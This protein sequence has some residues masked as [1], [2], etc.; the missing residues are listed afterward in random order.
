MISGRVR[1]EDRDP[2]LVEA[3]REA[4]RLEQLR[5]PVDPCGGAAGVVLLRD[6]LDRERRACE[7]VHAD[8]GRIEP[9]REVV[10]VRDHH[11]ADAAATSSSRVP[12]VR[13][14]PSRSPWPG[15]YSD[16]VPSASRKRLPS[17][18]RRGAADWPNR[19][20]SP[21]RSLGDVAAHRL[22]GREARHQRD[23][24]LG[25]ER[26]G[27]PPRLRELDLEEAP[28]VERLG[29]RL[30]AAAEP[31]RHAAREDDHRDLARAQRLRPAATASS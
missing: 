8:D 19:S 14:Q 6:D 24:D 5:P 29:D 27:E 30:D 13:T 18:R 31:R 9:R 25:A 4:E 10:D 20:G 3:G 12:E 7:H 15:P 1:V 28:A 23:R 21:R 11:R 2:A 16:A 22:V 17:G 26:V